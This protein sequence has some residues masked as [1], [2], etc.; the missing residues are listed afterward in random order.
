VVVDMST[1]AP[2]PTCAMAE[3]LSTRGA[4]MLDAPVSGGDTGAVA[5]TLSIM[6]GGKPEVFQRVNP[7]FECMGKTIVHVGGHGA[8]QVAKACN[9]IV[10]AVSRV[11]I[12]EAVVFARRN[13]VDPA[14]VIEALRGGLAG[15]KMLELQG[16]RMLEQDY[17]P[18]FKV[19]LQQ[20]DLRIATETAHRLG[21]AL[22]ATALVAQYLNA[23]VGAGDGELDAAAVG[24]VVER[25]N[26]E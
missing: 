14:R 23:L 13:G 19:R 12:S 1:I 7:L 24:R 3:E 22:P 16:K 8:G 15:G 6:V 26:G 11:G 4:E 10:T 21:V 25:M 17:K 2:G 9:Q 5:G 20:K 18:G